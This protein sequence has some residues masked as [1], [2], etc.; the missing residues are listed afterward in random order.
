[1]K[2]KKTQPL[3]AT[4][5]QWESLMCKIISAVSAVHRA[6]DSGLSFMFSFKSNTLNKKN[7]SHMQLW[8]KKFKFSHTNEIN[9]IC[10]SMYLFYSHH[11]PM[12]PQTPNRTLLLYIL[13]LSVGESRRTLCEIQFQTR[14][15]IWGKRENCVLLSSPYTTSR[16]RWRPGSC[17]IMVGNAFRIPSGFQIGR[18]RKRQYV[19]R[20]VS[21]VNWFQKWREHSTV[22]V[23]GLLIGYTTLDEPHAHM[24][25]HRHSYTPYNPQVGG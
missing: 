11:I 19:C 8:W 21:Q 20:M 6:W 14:F 16:R 12:L 4:R 22:Q 17:A 9:F 24:L 23:A 7:L 10:A 2:Q 3:Q 25:T 15:P 18:K 5:C 13:A 1:M